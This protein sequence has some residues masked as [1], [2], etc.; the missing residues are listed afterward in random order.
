MFENIITEKNFDFN[1]L[2][3]KVYKF[4]CKIGCSIIQNILENIDD[5]LMKERDKNKFR[6]KG[7]RRNCIKTIMGE[8]EYERR[9]YEIY[10]NKEY[11]YK[12]LLDEKV[13]MF[14]FG[15]ISNNL[16]EKVLDTV[17]QTTSYRKSEKELE[18]IS[19][20]RLSHESIRN[21]TMYAGEKIT[22]EEKEL[23]ELK[24]KKNLQKGTKEVPILFEEAD[25]LWISLQG[26]DRQEQIERNKEQYVNKYKIDE[27]KY[28]A[29]RRVKCE[30]K[31]HETYEGWKKGSKR[32]EIINKTYIVGFMNSREIRE[33]REAKIYNKYN[34][35]KIKYRVINGD[36]ATWINSLAGKNIIRQKDRFH[37]HQEI[38]R[39]IEDKE[40]QKKVRKMFENKEYAK[41]NPYIE[42]L[43]YKLGGEE[44]VVKKLEEL[45]KYLS[46]DLE[47]YTDIIK[48][49]EAPEGIEYRRLGTME[50]QIFT[51]LSK[52]LKGRKSFSKEGATKLAKV[53]ARYKEN[54]NKTEIKNIEKE[55]ILDYE[56]IEAEKYVKELEKRYKEN[57]DAY[58][59]T[60]GK[61]KE[62]IN[63]IHTIKNYN[64]N[65]FEKD[66]VRKIKDMIK[67]EANSEMSCWVSFFGGT[68][69]YRNRT[70]S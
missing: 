22:K 3:N 56:K 14:G 24:K 1:E 26:K 19:G 20:I 70:H 16:I 36:G 57:Y 30:L 21:I 7:K 38:I 35:E 66:V 63:E 28:V 58:I 68:R 52:R 37:I 50:S 8:V 13:D 40:E 32:H 41:I 12:Y 23:V 10:E 25:G 9:V 31:L 55:V 15:K 67:F 53:C 18:E 11:Q 6:N 33:L 42:E 60:A 29:P 2:E 54:G 27:K 49:P 59:A 47:R 4:V 51:V 44:K 62:G 45:Q 43:K 34:E 48:V 69:T 64:V 17:V 46:R 65:E 61:T 39:K 5:E